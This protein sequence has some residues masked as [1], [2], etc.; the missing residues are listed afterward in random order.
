[1]VKINVGCG[2]FYREGWTNLDTEPSVHPDVVG[3]ILALPFDAA[4]ATAVYCGHVLEHVPLQDIPAALA[5]VHRVLEP[6]GKL[7]VVGPDFTRICQDTPENEIEWVIYGSKRW[8][9]D[10]HQWACCESLVERFLTA[11]G[12]L[13]VIA[14]P[15][16]DPDL[17][18]WSI[19]GTA[20]PWQ[21]VVLATR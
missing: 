18:E 3:S 21:C 16:I 20:Y 12:F 7:C 8:A 11:A 9:G 5:E 10:F 15:I 13:D 19:P 17:G 2:P 6:G 4:S 1:V 14:R